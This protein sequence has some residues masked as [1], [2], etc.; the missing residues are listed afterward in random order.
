MWPRRPRG[1][2][3]AESGPGW[4]AGWSAGHRDI[5]DSVSFHIFIDDTVTL[6]WCHYLYLYLLWV[7]IIFYLSDWSVCITSLHTSMVPKTTCS[8]SK[9]LS[10]MRMTVAPPVV[11]P[12]L[13]LMAFIQRVA[14]GRETPTETE[15]EKENRNTAIVITRPKPAPGVSSSVRRGL[16]VTSEHEA[17]EKEQH[18]ELKSSHE[19]KKESGIMQLNVVKSTIYTEF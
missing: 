13:G 3:G 4:R 10:P 8:P 2:D 17:Q 1:C 6:K 18:E 9:K 11:Q 15:S 19:N 7:Q 16:T 12:S 14:A 5:R